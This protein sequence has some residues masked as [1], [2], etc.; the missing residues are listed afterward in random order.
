MAEP[1]VHFPIRTK[2]KINSQL[3]YEVKYEDFYSSSYW[4]LR[5][6]EKGI[7]FGFFA[8]S[9]QPNRRQVTYPVAIIAESEALVF[10][11]KEA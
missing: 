4:V 8:F 1:L 2:T 3:I 5:D 9:G 6:R 11:P 10:F 7:N